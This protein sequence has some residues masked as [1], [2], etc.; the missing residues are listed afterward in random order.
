MKIS[1]D[2]NQ[3]LVKNTEQFGQLLAHT[4]NEEIPKA[5]KS[6]S[7]IGKQLLFYL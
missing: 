5:I 2:A 3:A 1:S 4:L 6:K 7:N